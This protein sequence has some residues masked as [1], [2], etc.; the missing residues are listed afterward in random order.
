MQTEVEGKP[1]AAAWLVEITAAYWANKEPL[2]LD[3]EALAPDTSTVE[4][5]S[6]LVIADLAAR[7]GLEFPANILT[8]IKTQAILRDR[9]RL[10][11][12][13]RETDRIAA[14][15]AE[16]RPKTAQEP[17]LLEWTLEAVAT[18]P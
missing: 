3:V 1:D 5:I 16:R 17:D 6:D 7:E 13:G 4:A 2:P 8:D 18:A 15:V 14:A 12:Q 9:R 11:W 10:T